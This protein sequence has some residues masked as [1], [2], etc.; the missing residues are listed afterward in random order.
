MPQPNLDTIVISG[1]GWLLIVRLP[2]M[3]PV[4][5]LARVLLTVSIISLSTKA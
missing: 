4:M 3:A 1:S 2:G 5:L